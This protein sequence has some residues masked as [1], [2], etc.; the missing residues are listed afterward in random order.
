VYNATSRLASSLCERRRFVRAIASRRVLTL[1]SLSIWASF[2]VAWLYASTACARLASRLLICA[3]T[4][5]T[6]ASL[7]ARDEGSANA[8]GAVTRVPRTATT[9]IA[10]R[11]FLPLKRT[12][13]ERRKRLRGVTSAAP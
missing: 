3:R 13:D 2:A 5:R 6:C 11:H 8:E 10:A 1:R 7:K 4:C 9:T 12:S